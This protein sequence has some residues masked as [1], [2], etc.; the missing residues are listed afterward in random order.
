MCYTAPLPPCACV[1][2]GKGGAYLDSERLTRDPLQL[3][4]GEVG[5]GPQS[6]GRRLGGVAA[7]QVWVSS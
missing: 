4:V 7:Q 3:S 5:K 6:C 2:T 1:Q